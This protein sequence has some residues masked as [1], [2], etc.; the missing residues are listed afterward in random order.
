MEK[1]A[2]YLIIWDATAGEPGNAGWVPQPS[3]Y[4]GQNADVALLRSCQRSLHS[5]DV[6]VGGGSGIADQAQS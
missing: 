5:F 1:F 3:S 2:S 6:Y 4:E